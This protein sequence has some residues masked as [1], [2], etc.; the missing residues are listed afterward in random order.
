MKR[1]KA[2]M[3]KEIYHILRDPRSLVILF[4]LPII[5]ILIFGYS[6][7]FDLRNIETVIIDHS[8]SE[9]SRSLVQKFSNNRYYSVIRMVQSRRTYRF[10]FEKEFNSF[11]E[12]FRQYF[13]RI[14]LPVVND[15]G[16][17]I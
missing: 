12:I 16:I 17:R 2:V 3:L 5:M 15:T 4:L 9:L 13:K 8:R 14:P 7:S 11:P 6:L 1:T 10:H